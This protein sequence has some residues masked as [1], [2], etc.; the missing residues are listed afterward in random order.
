MAVPEFYLQ[1][2]KE[3]LRLPVPPE[4]HKF[5]SPFEYDDVKVAGLGDV[6]VFQRRGL[7]EFNIETFWP[8]YYNAS[9]CQYKPTITPSKFVSTIHKWRNARKPI[10]Y[11]VTGVSKVN[12]EVTIRDFEVEANPHGSPGDIYFTLK[13]VEYRKPVIKKVT[14]K[15][16]KKKK[17]T[18]KTSRPASKKKMSS[19]PKTYTVKKGDCLWNI[20]RKPSIYGDATKWRRIYNANKKLIGKNPN[21]IYP[22]QKLVIPR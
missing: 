10:R 16:Q 20:A 5:S 18:K 9:Y 1:S 13:L 21:L 15:T 19:K 14:I 12:L 7:R 4:S 3:R 17:A 8:K 22:G 2:G 6:T 11:I